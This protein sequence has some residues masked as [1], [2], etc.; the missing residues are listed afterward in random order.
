MNILSNKMKKF[1]IPLLIFLFIVYSIL[2]GDSLIYLMVYGDIYEFSWVIIYLISFF[3]TLLLLSVF[4]LY[5]GIKIL[6][7]GYGSFLQRI[8][9]VIF[10]IS[11]FMACILMSDSNW[12]GKVLIM[13]YIGFFLNYFSDVSSENKNIIVSTSKKNILVSFIVIILFISSFFYVTDGMFDNYYLLI[14]LATQS[15]AIFSTV[16]LIISGIDKRYIDT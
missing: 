6:L 2:Y 8:S 10:L 7:K 12:F 4:I 3:V 11:S 1:F 13:F 5:P 15:I 16:Y 14:Y 9:I